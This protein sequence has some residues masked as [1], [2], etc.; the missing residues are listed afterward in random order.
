M[1]AEFTLL[2]A[3]RKFFE[4]PHEYKTDVAVYQGGF[5]SGKTWS[6]SL[7]GILLA[8]R[9]PGIRGLVGAQ[10]YKLLRDTT[11]QSYFEHLDN[12]GVQYK[13]NKS[14]DK[15]TFENSSEILFRHLEEPDKLK[16]L[17]LGF[18]EIEEMSDVP[19]S[20]F[21][22]LIG[23]LRQSPKKEWVNFHYRLFGHTNPEAARGWIY[24]QFVRNPKKNF[25]RI[26]APTTD[27]IYLPPEYIETMKESYNEDYFKMYV[28]GE[29]I[30]TSIG[31]VTKHFN[32]DKQVLPEIKIN[33]KFPIHITCDFN[34]DPMC[35]YICQHY[36]NK[37]YI[38][39]EHVLSN[40]TTS[41]SAQILS[42][43]LTKYKKHSI[44]INGDAS[45]QAKKTTG[46]DY[47]ILKNELTRK[48]F[49]N[50]DIRVM[51]KNPGI[52]WRIQCWNNMIYGPD[53]EPHVFI[54]SECKYLLYNI[55]NLM[56]EE[57]SSK[58]KKVST[59]KMKSDPYAKYLIHP[60][61]AVSYLICLYYPIKDI[62]LKT[63]E[64]KMSDT[65]SDKYSKELTKW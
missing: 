19:Y 51:N 30:D 13:Y 34:V 5:G 27:N 6:G 11:L 59:G 46:T 22:M 42:D 61:D 56:V 44:I 25:R 36:D 8:L 18:V 60:I 31:L 48:G 41:L 23:R 20:T 21:S 43:L 40:T 9:F 47:I 52:E 62:N 16:S 3:Q 57:G 63:F 53:K 33:D 64:G 65:F 26:L 45:G 15:I 14:E 10:T 50:I 38:I 58:P 55:E 4:I 29:D 1:V 7:L 28:L 32:Y 17:N 37:V 24:E 39:H 54:A 35:W 12:M 49:E 2:P